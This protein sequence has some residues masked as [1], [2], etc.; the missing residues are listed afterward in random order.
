ME[1]TFYHHCWEDHARANAADSAY[2][3]SWKCPCQ[4]HNRVDTSKLSGPSSPGEEF[5]LL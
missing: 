3:P 1:Q 4:C 2:P 5:D